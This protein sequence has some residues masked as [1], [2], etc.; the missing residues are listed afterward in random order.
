MFEKI[1][2]KKFLKAN[3][4]CAAC[5]RQGKYTKA[6]HVFIM[7][8]GYKESRCNNCCKPKILN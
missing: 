6:T 3:P 2:E 8:N 5:M 1:K 7:T 4:L